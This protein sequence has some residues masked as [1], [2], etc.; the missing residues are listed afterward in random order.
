MTWTILGQGW[1]Y[2]EIMMD[3]F[4]RYSGHMYSSIFD[5]LKKLVA[6]T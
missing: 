6:Y 1:K 5:N 3:R 2:Q 4:I